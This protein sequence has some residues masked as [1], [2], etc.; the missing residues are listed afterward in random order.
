MF[1][2]FNRKK[3]ASA[4][5]GS[6]RRSFEV[7]SPSSLRSSNVEDLPSIPTLANFDTLMERTITMSKSSNAALAAALFTAS[8]F[9]GSAALAAGGDGDYYPGVSREQAESQNVDRF[10]T[11]SIHNGSV[12]TTTS[13]KDQ[14]PANGDYYRGLDRTDR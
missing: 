4:R 5:N 10:T 3:A 1:E 12:T 2:F 7:A 6:P 13:I 11:Q 14:G 8:V 9:G